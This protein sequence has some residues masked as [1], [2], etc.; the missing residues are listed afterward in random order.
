MS[1]YYAPCFYRIG[2]VVIPSYIER[3]WSYETSQELESKQCEN[4]SGTLTESEA[5]QGKQIA[6]Y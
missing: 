5:H 3:P 6:T 2:F 1:N 4:E